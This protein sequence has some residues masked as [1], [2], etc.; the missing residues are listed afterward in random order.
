MAFRV[1]NMETR[2]LEEE[3][4][5]REILEDRKEDTKNDIVLTITNSS[6]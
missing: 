3:L 6:V 5:A 4:R 2:V 1:V